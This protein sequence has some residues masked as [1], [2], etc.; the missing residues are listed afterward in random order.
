[1]PEALEMAKRAGAQGEVPVGAIIVKDGN[2]IARAHNQLGQGGNAI[3]HAEICAINKACEVLGQERLDGCD[4]YVTLEPCA[5]C[6]GAISHARIRRLYFGASD[7]KS[8]A[9]V[10][11]AKIYEHAQT[12][13]KPEIYEGICAPEAAALLTDFFKSKRES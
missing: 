5:M 7:P 6:A 13:H 10:N 4:L 8:G 12:H 1:M 2:I 11:G 3:Q 9:V